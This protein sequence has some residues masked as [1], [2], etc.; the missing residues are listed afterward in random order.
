MNL[1]NPALYPLIEEQLKAAQ[2]FR[3][4]CTN[5][6]LVRRSMEARA[7]LFRALTEIENASKEVQTHE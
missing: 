1:E 7:A 3:E 6:R 4:A 2:M 5:P